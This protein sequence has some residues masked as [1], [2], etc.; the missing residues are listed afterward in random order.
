MPDYYFYKF[1]EI[2]KLF[3]AENW[4]DIARL[5]VMK[6]FAAKEELKQS[7]GGIIGKK[8]KKRK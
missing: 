7:L 1:L 8:E 6:L 4:K 2:E 5:K 3:E